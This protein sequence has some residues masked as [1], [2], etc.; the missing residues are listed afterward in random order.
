MANARG[1]YKCN[2][3]DNDYGTWQAKDFS[4]YR[5]RWRELRRKH[6]SE[7][8]ESFTHWRGSRHHRGGPRESTAQSTAC[9]KRRTTHGN[10]EEPSALAANDG[11]L[12]GSNSRGKHGGS[13]PTHGGSTYQPNT[14]GMTTIRPERD[15]H[16]ERCGSG[17]SRCRQ[18]PLKKQGRGKKPLC[19]W[20]PIW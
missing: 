19:P 9:G 14:C 13:P 2:H 1:Q 8:K 6:T 3:H 17:Q 12:N 4:S 18:Q 15:R 7:E 5:Q 11:E 10:A 16:V 20:P